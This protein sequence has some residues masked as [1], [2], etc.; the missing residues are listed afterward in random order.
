MST[1]APVRP[2]GSEVAPAPPAP[3]PQP[4]PRPAA[5]GITIGI[6][7]IVLGSI[8][9]LEALGVAVP[10][11]MIVPIVLISLGIG[12]A[13]SGA[14]GEDSGMVGLA[15]FLG[16]VL[17]IG[18]LLFAVL[19]V[20]IR[21][22]VGERVHAPV[23]AAELEDAYGLFAGTVTLDLQDLVLPPGTAEVRAA[24]V[25]GEVVVIV[26]EGMAVD[27]D[28]SAAGGTIDLFGT[29]TEGL[30]LRDEFTTEGFDGATTRLQ[31]ELRAGLGEVRL[32][33]P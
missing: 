9:L 24:T 20:P 19:D 12:V 1:E 29:T 17:A 10:F 15:V 16:V 4:G 28:A 11:G 33:T 3:Q 14:R 30:G 27:V 26:P 21:G 8:W 13:V 7:L 25:L 2:Q 23:T 22:G 6:V 31:L 32:T 5:G 18:S